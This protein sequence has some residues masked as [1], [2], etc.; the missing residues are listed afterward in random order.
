MIPY[1]RQTID[2]DDIAAVTAAMRGDFLTQGP[3][4]EAFER[5][6]AERVEARHAIAY[7]NGTAALHGACA[8]AGLGAGDLVATSPLSF[9]A[10]ANCARYVGADVTFV[11]IDA[12]TLNLDVAAVPEGVDAVVPVHFTGL[13]VD[14][15]AMAN[16]PEVVIEDAAHA[17]GAWTPDGP[18]GNGA[19]SDMTCFSFHPVKPVTT[20]EGGV[21]TTNND[22]LAARLRRFRSHGTEKRP[23]LGGWYY[24]I[25][26]IGMNYRLTDIQAALGLSQMVKLDRF[27]ARRQEIAARYDDLLAGLPVITPPRAPEGFGH[28]YHL[29]AIRVANRRAVY[30]ALH[31]DGIAVQVHYVPIHH[32]PIYRD[33]GGTYP[34][35]DHAYDQLLSMPMFP[36]LTDEQQLGAVEALERAIERAGTPTGAVE[37]GGAVA[38]PLGH[39][40]GT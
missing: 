3:V 29:Y 18:V 9:A 17:L 26:E 30:E 35:T 12:A 40:L 27:I 5:A 31:A 38:E 23:E 32:H 13:P 16:R 22:E 1:G 15:A 7:A 2:D 20:G 25:N 14:L 28:G 19:Q 36:A 37:H 10:S 33:V 6:V 4:L 8:A 21:V 11:D 24:E 34:N 39:A